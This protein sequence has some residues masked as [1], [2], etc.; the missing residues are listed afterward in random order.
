VWPEA[1]HGTAYAAFLAVTLG[2]SAALLVV[3]VTTVRVAAR[4]QGGRAA[5][6]GRRRRWLPG[7][8]LDANPVLWRE[9]R[10]RSTGWARSVW[11]SYGVLALG[12]SLLA[13]LEARS[14]TLPY[15]V[16]A[17]VNAAQVALGLLLLS[18]TSVSTLAE[19][20]SAGS[21]AVLLATPLTTRTILWGKWWGAYRPV[22]GVALLPAL[23]ASALNP[24]GGPGLGVALLV[25]LVL[26]YGAAVTSLGLVLGTWVCRPGRA[27]AWAISLYVFASVGCSAMVP[28][29]FGRAMHPVLGLAKA[30]PLYGPGLLT[31]EAGFPPGIGRGELGW[32]LFWTLAHLI[33]AVALYRATLLTFDDCLGRLPEKPPVAPRSPRSR[34]RLAPL[35]AG[36]SQLLSEPEA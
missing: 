3:A 7:P 21:L 31:H 13:V 24:P 10:R 2:L 4:R 35:R 22:L 29:L 34:P 18:A 6:A 1:V 12:F 36:S 9:W 25:V 15:D 33:A 23:V 20:R 16:C 28:G 32:T 8:S 26:A 17:F 30:S 11:V 5:R 14:R 27:V 19:E